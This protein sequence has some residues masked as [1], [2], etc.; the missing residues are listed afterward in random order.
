MR[1][2]SKCNRNIAIWDIEFGST[3]EERRE[4]EVR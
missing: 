3:D 4:G 1:V 2:G